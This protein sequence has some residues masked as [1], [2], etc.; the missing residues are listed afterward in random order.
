VET[1]AV[2]T[3]PKSGSS[4][5]SKVIGKA[6][7][8]FTV[9][10][11]DKGGTG[12]SVI[13]RF[14]AELHQQRNTG[15]YLVD[16]DGTTASLS[17]HFG[18]PRENAGNPDISNPANPVHTFSLHGSERD[19]D[20]IASLLEVDAPKMLLDL[21]ATSLTVLRKI[22][23]EYRWTAMLA[24]HGWRPTVVASVTPFEESIFDLADAM[25]LFGDRADYIAV[26]NMGLAEERADFEIWDEGE[27]RPKFLAAGGIEVVFPKLKPRIAAKL[28]KYTL[29]F[30]GGKSS[31]HLIL[32]DRSRLSKWF[33]DAETAFAL[34]ADRL[35]I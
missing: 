5:G 33:S 21:P 18:L 26:V 30:D 11:K 25:E 6:V 7:K 28:Q 22:E 32:A 1:I 27:T 4:R 34:A 29:T 24:E 23:A 2:E 14:L 16:G 13:A 35:G 17:K 8:R 20:T 31:S 19:R 10:V 12:A 9:F 3:A 15:A